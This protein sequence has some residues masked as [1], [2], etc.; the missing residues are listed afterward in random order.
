MNGRRLRLLVWKEFLQLRRDPMFLR[1]AMAMPIVQLVMFGYVVAADVTHLP[2]AIVDLDRTPVSRQLDAAF[3]ASD[4]FDVVARPAGEDAL[5]P[6]L[7]TDAVA[8]AVVIPAGTQA[9]LERERTPGSASSS[10]ARTARRRP[11]ARGTPCASSA[12]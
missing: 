6:L 4:Y 12:D 2:V 8:V 5:R 9:A 3:T 1:M 10:T 7:D 11:S